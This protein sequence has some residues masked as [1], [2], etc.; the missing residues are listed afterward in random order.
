[1]KLG[2]DGSAIVARDGVRPHRALRRPAPGGG[3]QVASVEEPAQVEREPVRPVLGRLPVVEQGDG[4]VRPGGGEKEPQRRKDDE[5]EVAQDDDGEEV[6]REVEP[7][8]RRPGVGV[9]VDGRVHHT[10]LGPGPD[11]GRC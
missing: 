7:E 11:P 4:R 10:G 5:P 2:E 9:S 8:E 1:M 6:A 3:A